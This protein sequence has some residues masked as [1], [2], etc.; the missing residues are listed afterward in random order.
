MR[1]KKPYFAGGP[2]AEFWFSLSNPGRMQP[3]NIQPTPPAKSPRLR[4]PDSFSNALVVADDSADLTRLADSLHGGGFAVWPTSGSAQA[5]D[6]L[7]ENADRIGLALLGLKCPDAD[8]VTL[9]RTLCE[10][11]PGLICCVLGE[12]EGPCE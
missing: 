5:L 1:N 12:D 3:K 6:V 8:A 10:A 2:G 11:R 7:R 9:A 4:Q